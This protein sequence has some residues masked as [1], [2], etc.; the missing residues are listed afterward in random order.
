A[1]VWLADK[2]WTRVDPTAAVAPQR[3]NAGIDAALPDNALGPVFA[4]KDYP[5]LRKL[6]LNWDAVN[7]GWNQWVLGY[8]QEK[9]MALLNRLT[10]SDLSWQDLVIGLVLSLATVGLILSAFLLRGKRR[11]LDPVQRLYVQFLRK[12]ERAGLKRLAHEGPQDFGHRAARRLPDRA[13]E[14]E[15][16]TQAYTGIRYRSNISAEALAAL[17]HMIK[18][19]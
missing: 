12:L 1:E 6:Y 10:G 7:N 13:K 4:R 15:A 3:V 18:A 8:D 5:L 17:R 9:Q 16:I 14:I 11:I 19:F 2:G